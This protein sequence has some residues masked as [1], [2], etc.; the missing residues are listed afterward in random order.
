MCVSE[1]S[2]LKKNNN[3]NDKTQVWCILYPN[4][5]LKTTYWTLPNIKMSV[6]FFSIFKYRIRKWK[7]DAPLFESKEALAH[8]W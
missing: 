5:I 8:E 6:F 1:K 4:Y 7:I 3:N 2:Y